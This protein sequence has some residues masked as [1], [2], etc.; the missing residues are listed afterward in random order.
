MLV[1]MITST[2]FTRETPMTMNRMTVSICADGSDDEDEDGDDDDDD[3][4]VAGGYGSGD[5]D[6]TTEDCYDNEQLCY[7]I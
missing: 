6:V 3:D 5:D 7:R 2:M 4:R 1:M